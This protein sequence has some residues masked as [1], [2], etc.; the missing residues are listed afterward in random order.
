ML[1]L[2]KIFLVALLGS[3][4]LTP[5][6]RR[7]AL[8]WGMVD[9]PD[10]HRKLHGGA[11]PLG[12]GVAVL[13]GFAAA[14]AAAFVYSSRWRER[15]AADWLFLTGLLAAAGVIC[16]LGYLDD[17]HGLR[18]R[19]KL[20]GQL[21]ATTVL[22]CGGLVIE[23]FTIFGWQIEL[24]VL[25]VPFTLFWLLGATNALNLI[26]GVDG[27]ATS[28]GIVL[29]LAVSVMSLLAGHQADA[30]L[31]MA[32]AGSLAGF[33]IYNAPPAS[34]FLGDA[35]S[36]FI[37]LVLGALAIRSSLKGPATIALAAPTA[38]LAVPIFDVTMA[39]LRRTLTGR[40]IY[41]ADRGHLHHRLILRGY[42]PRSTVLVIGLLCALTA[43]GAVFSEYA[44][45]DILAISAILAVVAVLALTRLFGHQEFVLLVRRAKHFVRSLVPHRGRLGER[46]G[47]LQTLLQGSPQ[48][49]ELWHTLIDYAE[50]FDLSSIQLNVLMPA[51]GQEYHASWNRK[52][53]SAD[54]DL[55]HSD[56]PLMADR[57][58]VGRLRIT[59]RCCNG[60]VCTWMA[61][62][63]A[64]LK[65]FET[66]MLELID[67]EET[68]EPAARPPR[69]VPATSG[70]EV[71][72]PR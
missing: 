3:L 50:R 51:W 41:S 53:L 56:I 61:D 30:L 31:A 69:V 18:G 63:I 52:E 66:Q 38:L 9:E 22:V 32:V 57:I 44:Q 33:L 58:T 55:W 35:G 40:S 72:Q 1:T 42:G 54:A 68:F 11:I 19:Q 5:L 26:D 49:V 46:H 64:G 39:I 59:G 27:L 65:P 12:G 15:F 16:F 62:L 21:V 17:R 25:A 29:S 47:E 24:G 8:R 2:A 37:G 28:V 4:L 10:E 23:R 60:S 45:N 6:V 14:L 34:I 70:T 7:L 36:M 71:G 48:W 43:V 20:L 67:A 13:G